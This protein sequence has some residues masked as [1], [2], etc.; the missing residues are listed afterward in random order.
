MKQKL[1]LEQYLANQASEKDRWMELTERTFNFAK[2]ARYHFQNGDREMRRS[3]FASLGFEPLF[4]RPKNQYRAA[5]SVQDD[6]A[7]QRRN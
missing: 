1:E 6:H 7:K 3:I 2:Y 4:A 5:L